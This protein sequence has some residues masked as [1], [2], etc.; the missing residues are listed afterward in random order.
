[1]RATGFK[2]NDRRWQQVVIA[3]GRVIFFCHQNQVLL[4]GRDTV[5]WTIG[6]RFCNQCRIKFACQYCCCQLCRI[7]GAQLQV[8]FREPPVV[9]AQRPR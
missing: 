3:D 4:K 6:N 2:R 9:F 5:E 8:D 1:M 7:S